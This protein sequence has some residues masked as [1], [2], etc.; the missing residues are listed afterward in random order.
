MAKLSHSAAQE[1]E[2]VEEEYG[3]G[4][5]EAP[6]AIYDYDADAAGILSLIARERHVPVGLMLHPSRCQAGVAEARQLAMYLMHVVL[7]RSLTEIGI[8]FGRDRT[9]VGHA[10]A[11]VE[12]RRDEPAFEREVR[13]LERK[14]GPVAMR[15]PHWFTEGT[16]HAGE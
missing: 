13:R 2:I 5:E 11:A 9:T 4:W 12:D 7:Q 3:V 10:C 14:I 8:F 16:R 15:L 1:R 6:Q